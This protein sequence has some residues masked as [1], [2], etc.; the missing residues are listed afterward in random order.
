MFKNAR[1]YRLT[2]PWPD[3]ET[4]LSDALSGASFA[5]CG[6]L[7]E[8][9]SGWEAPS[10]DP[11]AGFAR[12][13]A[14]ADLL[15]LRSQ[16]RLLPAA[17]INEALEA[18]LDEFRERMAQEP[19]RREKRRL[20]DQTRDELMPKAL[21]RSERTKGCLFIAENI[22]AVDAGSPAKAERFLEYLRAPLGSVDPIP[23]QFKASIANLLTRIFL[24]D[25]PG[26]IKLGRECRMQD[27]ADK[28]ASVRWADMDLSDASIRKHVRDGMKLSHLGIEFGNVMSCVI[29]EHGAL[30][31]LKFLGMD[32][33]DDLDDEDP[34]ARFDAEF[35]LLTGT[36]RQLL[37]VLTQALGGVDMQA[38]SE[39]F[40]Q[41]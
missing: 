4:A 35:V 20:K 11:S 21:L 39:P 31:K 5:P 16:N 40:S 2:G 13:V 15:Q 18:R 36:L 26:G 8:K 22:F 1:F 34:L 24:G 29:D 32:A 27:P 38:G 28:R 19:S 3:S 41:R 25:P 9:T 6:P 12:R 33:K 17:A 14:G 23:L 37:E 7:T 10:T 30:G